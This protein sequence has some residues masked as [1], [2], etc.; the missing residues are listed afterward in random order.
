MQRACFGIVRC[1]AGLFCLFIALAPSRFVHAGSDEVDLALVL[2]MDCSSSVDEQEFSLQMEGLG[3]AFQ[4]ADVKAAIRH[5]KLQRIAVNV[6]EWSGNNSQAIVMQ[7]T[8][9]A[10]DDDAQSFGEAVEDLPRNLGPGATSISSILRFSDVLLDKAPPAARRVIDVSG[11]GPSNIGGEVNAARDRL[12]DKGITI[13]AL[14]ILNEWRNL[15]LYF[16]KEVAGGEGNFVV[17]A[18]DLGAYA[19]AIQFKLIKEITGPGIS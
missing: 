2:A 11:D 18:N 1:I 14:A 5:G 15:D 10:N 9:I 12:V 13:N 8:I 3:R 19:D 16:Q 4:T 6:V 7:W 17:P